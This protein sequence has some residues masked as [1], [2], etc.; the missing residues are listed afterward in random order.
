VAAVRLGEHLLA[1]GHIS[2]SQLSAALKE[3]QITGSKLGIILTCLHRLHPLTLLHALSNQSQLPSVNLQAQPADARFLSYDFLNDYIRLNAIPWQQDQHGMII[4]CVDLTE[5][6]RAWATEYYGDSTQFMLTTWRDIRTTLSTHFANLIDRDARIGLLTEQ[7]HASAYRTLYPAQR[8]GIVTLLLTMAALIFWQPWLAVP[9]L[10]LFINIFYL[11]TIGLKF[12]L[13][14]ATARFHPIHAPPIPDHALPIYSILIPLY[15]ESESIPRL[16]SAMRALDYPKTH[17]DIKLVVEDDDQAT[18][19][20]IMASKPEPYF[21]IIRV[22]YS[23]PRTKPKACD[24]ALRFARGEFITIYDAEDQP[25]PQQLRKAVAAFRAL[26]ANISCLQARLNYYNWPENILT[27]LFAIEYASLFDFML[28]GMQALRLP[29]PL[30]GTSNHFPLARLREIGQWDP[31]NVT[32][33]ADLGLRLALSGYETRMLDSITL[34]ESPLTLRAWMHQR[35]RWVKGYMQTWLVMMR[36]PWQFYRNVGPAGFWGVHF[37]IGGP[38]IVFLLGPLLW[39]LSIGWWITGHNT[40]IPDWLSIACIGNL[41]AGILVHLWLARL[42]IMRWQW[43]G[44]ARA[45]ALYPFYWLL[46]SLASYR[47]LWQLIRQPHRW[48]KTAHGLSSY[49]NNQPLLSPHT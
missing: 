3:Q 41:I 11:G 4:A 42:A 20:A 5:E 10:L 49:S 8:W 27:R 24:Y 30:G 13:Y 47:A 32:E 19:N 15:K 33:D 6:V 2:E 7:P 12:V 38:C 48:D 43:D 22:P 39:A 26:P 14:A 40:F 9:A 31:Y 16:L 25:E 35:A 17:L 45:M 44:M 21:E 36:R 34:E 29:I 1:T 28:P 46:H 18:I 37:F 23:E